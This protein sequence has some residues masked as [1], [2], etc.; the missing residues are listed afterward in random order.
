MSQAILISNN[1][2]TNSLFEVNL[3]AYVAVNV[4]IKPS[5]S[6][7]LEL[8][9]QALNVD[10][11][12]IYKDVINT[13]EEIIAFMDELKSKGLLKPIIIL[14]ELDQTIPGTIEIKSKYNIK[15]LLQAMAKVLEV[16]AKEMASMTVAKYFPIPIS[17]FAPTEPSYCDIYQRD[18]KENFEYEYKKIMDVGK[19][20]GQV[21]LEMRVLGETHLY[22]DSSK[23]L[24]FINQASAA[25]IGELNNENITVGEQ[26]E[27]TQQAMGMVAE[28]VFESEVISNQVA[29]VSK[30]CIESINKV[31]KKMP[32]LK[33]MLSLL[34]ENPSDYCYKH[35]VLTTF[36]ATQI[37]GKISWGSV[38]QQNK[39]AFS[40]FF[41]D[42]YLVPLYKK[43]PDAIIE[44]DLLFMDGVTDEEKQVVLDHAKMAGQLVK[45]FP[46]C[47]MGADS[48]I[49][50]HHGMTNGQGFAMSFKDDI[51]P[52]AKI[53]IVAEDIAIGVLINSKKNE[54]ISVDTKAICKQLVEKYRNH[55]YH[56]IIT[57]FQEAKL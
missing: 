50:Q 15:G 54:K 23:R 16:T 18:Q 47:P 35:S 38:E 56:K 46:R 31:I 29:E 25:L 57:A 8:L 1:E 9:D 52:L 24:H 21:Q 5:L 19:P 34:M 49:T 12:I 45:S 51:S 41:H 39:V 13:A 40:L 44:E 3:R 2:V 10:A 28:E 11:I 43:F 6:S 32:N 14:G 7:S 17:L 26:V 22:I 37:I 48:L 20:L 55:T 53:M 30:A 27:I 4:T 33:D 36:I 42:I